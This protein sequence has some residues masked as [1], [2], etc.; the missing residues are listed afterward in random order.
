[1][2]RVSA[3]VWGLILLASFVLALFSFSVAAQAAGKLVV[4]SAAPKSMSDLVVEMWYKKYPNIK[5]E[6]ISSGTGEIATRIQAEKSNPK[7]DIIFTMGKE[8]I[9]NIPNL[10]EPYK[11]ANDSFFHASVKDKNHRYYGFSMPLQVFIVNT[12]LVSDPPKAWKDLAD[13]KWKGKLIWS[14]PAL[15]GSGLA[16]LNM[17][18]QLYGWDFVKKVVNNAVI[19]PSSKL[20]YQGVA[21]GEYAIGL[22]GEANVLELAQQKYPVTAVYPSDGTGER[23]D[24]VAIIKGCPNPDEAKKFMD[25]VTSKEVY[26]AMA[27]K[28]S[29]RM[30]RKDIPVL[31]TMIPT[32]KIV[33]FDYDTELAAKNRDAYLEKFEDV[34]ASKK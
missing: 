10:V 22:T 2:P 8:T 33:F 11:N 12:K 21:S 7:G 17:M 30:V 9:D 13:P 19:T 3:K 27:L 16:Q 24:V 6:V 5:I 4:Y 28:E 34:F 14:N 1:M 23:F 31:S 26:T 18:V 15:S 32:E 25:F 20:A 29:R